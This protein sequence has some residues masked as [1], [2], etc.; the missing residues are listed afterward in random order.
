MTDAEI[1]RKTVGVVGGAEEFVGFSNVRPIRFGELDVAA[2]SD[3]VV[4]ADD[5]ERG[6]VG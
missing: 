2:G 5:K 1:A 4:D 3:I 6:G